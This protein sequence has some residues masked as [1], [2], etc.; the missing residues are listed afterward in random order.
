MAASRGLE[1]KRSGEPEEEQVS[2]RDRDSDLVA[3]DN[4]SGSA[5]G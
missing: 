4:S 1:T 3:I 2:E 5:E